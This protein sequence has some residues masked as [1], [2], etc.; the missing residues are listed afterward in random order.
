[1]GFFDKLKERV[2]KTRSN[3]SDKLNTVIKNFRRVDEE[4]FEELEE[5]LILSD[6]GM[7]TADKVMDGLRE[8]VREQ[9]IKDT[10]QIRGI[11]IDIVSGIMEAQPL[12]LRYP[13]VMLLVGVNGVGKTTA[14]GKL[15]AYYQSKGAS[16]MLAAADTFRAAASEQLSIWGERT[17]V[18]VIKYAE[19]AD[20][21]AVVF[22]AID[23]A[24]H[25]KTNILI[26]DTAGRL[27]NKKNLMAELEKIDRVIKNSYP[28]AQRET[29][30]VLDATTGQ[31][32][33]SQAK[34][35]AQ[36]VPV[37]GIVLTKLDGTAKGGVVCAVKETVGVPV[38][39]IGVG[40]GMDDL[41]PFD[42]QEFA[43]AILE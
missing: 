6:M 40:E 4:F 17:G 38:R 42:A 29:F 41:Q 3:I 37:T 9:N 8:A 30:L 18:R 25:A 31:N 28:E 26:V 10:E 34:V 2:G 24:K 5:I 20:P 35:F 39:F 33:I 13:C 11:L 1:M 32:A 7:E 12:D 14:I 43:R 22:D 15:S 36:A 19:G 23:A 16:V 21:A 27:H